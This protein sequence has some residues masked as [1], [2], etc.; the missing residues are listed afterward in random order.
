[1]TKYFDKVNKR[2]FSIDKTSA[3]NNIESTAVGT[4]ISKLFQW[5]AGVQIS[6]GLKA[7]FSKLEQPILSRHRS[8]PMQSE[9]IL[10][11][12]VR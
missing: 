7:K 2:F 5:F 3:F 10:V 4:S 12:R 6:S 8:F 1:M 9:G 11:V